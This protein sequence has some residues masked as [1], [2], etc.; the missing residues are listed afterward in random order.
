MCFLFCVKESG[1]KGKGKRCG[2]GWMLHTRIRNL[3]ATTIQNYLQAALSCQWRSKIT[4][5]LQQPRALFGRKHLDNEC[6]YAGKLKNSLLLQ[7]WKSAPKRS[8][9]AWKVSSTLKTQEQRRPEILSGH[10]RLTTCDFFQLAPPAL[11]SAQPEMLLPQALQVPGFCWVWDTMYW[12]PQCARV[13][14]AALR[15]TQRHRYH[16]LLRNWEGVLDISYH[17]PRPRC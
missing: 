16:F 7:P 17:S 10:S 9:T 6:F 8:H 12:T 13:S 14:A 5:S 11:R 4:P 2:A 15:W 3:K 1:G